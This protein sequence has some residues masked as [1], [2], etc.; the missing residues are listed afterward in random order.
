MDILF[1]CFKK[2]VV[3]LFFSFS[4]VSCESTVDL[5][6][7][8]GS[9]I[10][11]PP[12]PPSPPNVTITSPVMNSYF[13]SSISLQGVCGSGTIQ[14]T[15]D[16]V[17]SPI[18]GA[19]AG[20]NYSQSLTLTPGDGSKAVLVSQTNTG[21]TTARTR[22]FIKD[23]TAP[24]LG[25][26]SDGGA[27]S[28]TITYTP[29]ISWSA[30]TDSGSGLNRY[31]AAIGTTAGAFDVMGWTQMTG[32]SF[33]KSGLTLT[34]GQTYYAAVKAVDNVGN[35]STASVSS[36]WTIRLPGT[37]DSSYGASG[38]AT[39][40]VGDNLEQLNSSV[41][42]NDEK[43][44]V[45]GQKGT[46]GPASDG[47]AVRYNTDGTLDTTF[48]IAGLVTVDFYGL[49]DQ[50]T[51]ARIDASSRIVLVG[52]A[53]DG[54]NYHFAISRLNT[55]G[56]L[57]ST[58]GSGGKVTVPIGANTSYAADVAIQTDGKILIA[59]RATGGSG[60]DFAIVRLNADGTLDT[61][62]GAGTGKALFDISSNLDFCRAVGVQSNGKIILA[63]ITHGALFGFDFSL[64]RLNS[65][66]TIDSTFNS[67][68]GKRIDDISG[69]DDSLS[70]ITIA[71]NDDIYAVGGDRNMY[72]VRYN[73]EGAWQT[74]I[75]VNFGYSSGEQAY[76]L[77]LQP[78]G[79]LI[80]GGNNG[81]S[82]SPVTLVRV[83]PVTMALDTS[84][85]SNGIVETAIGTHGD[86]TVGLHINTGGKILAVGS[87]SNGSE[88]NT[89]SQYFP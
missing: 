75:G 9:T 83:N 45:A 52:N 81:S 27:I 51:K 29:L 57:D 17:G 77:V 20:A 31:E 89:I 63:G 22:T 4:L 78:D 10:D 6:S 24:T 25:S 76:A 67:G 72:A 3:P 36:G 42:Q 49:Q 44:I 56:T 30:A 33:L 39:A 40:G 74:H 58:F 46:G 47:A 66:G 41:M 1:A 60:T 15:G 61:S 50:F 87:S 38:I 23:A 82:A 28:N 59:G 5:D 43:I 85:G 84:F 35:T 16:I 65:N 62:F 12:A 69:Y 88:A 80:F 13:Q 14:F 68:T 34:N 73:S 8:N 37:L 32:T 48:G 79:K 53:Y 71:A 19:C 64:V 21:G 7:E 26:V 18:S 11:Q 70:A 55:N 86:Q 54:T 2:V